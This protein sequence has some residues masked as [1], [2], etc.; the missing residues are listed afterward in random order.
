[1]RKYE[2]FDTLQAAVGYL[3]RQGYRQGDDGEWRRD[4]WHRQANPA[5]WK[6]V[7]LLKTWLSG[8]GE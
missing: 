3:T 6:C 5:H 1:M 7:Q 4:S 2:P 8:A